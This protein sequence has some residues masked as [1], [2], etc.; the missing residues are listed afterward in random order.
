MSG[1]SPTSDYLEE[2]Y[3]SEP[4][5][6]SGSDQIQLSPPHTPLAYSTH[7]RSSL[8]FDSPKSKKYA[9]SIKYHCKQCN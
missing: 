3:T 6:S 5:D 2:S 1:A 4:A 9:L 8:G 7:S